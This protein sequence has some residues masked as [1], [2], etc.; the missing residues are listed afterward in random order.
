M[1]SHSSR[2]FPYITFVNEG[3]HKSRNDKFCRIVD[4]VLKSPR[5]QKVLDI[6]KGSS[7]FAKCLGG[8]R[9]AAASFSPLLFSG[10][11]VRVSTFGCLMGR[12]HAEQ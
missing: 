10:V 8:E 1:R 12:G 7:L 6:M 5:V 4:V 11:R 3:V 9:Q 2:G